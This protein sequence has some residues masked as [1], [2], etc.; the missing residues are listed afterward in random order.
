MLLSAWAGLNPD[1]LLES[2][3]ELRPPG[4]V[5]ERDFQAVCIRCGHC[6]QIC[7]TTC[8]QPSILETGVAGFMTPVARMR[9]G[10]C[11][12]NCRACGE[13]CPTGAIR[14]LTKPEKPFAKIGNAIIDKAKCIV[15]EQG[16]PCLVCDENCPWG[17]IYWRQN[18]RGERTP[19][20]DENRCNGCGQ[21]EH[22]CPVVGSAAIRVLPAGRIRLAAGSFASEARNRG[23]ILEE[24][25]EGEYGL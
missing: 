9:L 10:P 14:R 6:V 3:E 11:D 16:K 4:A 12:P 1:R 23:L 20:V 5:P 21:C 19:F 7:P 25:K 13:V 24:K 8:L 15:W 17:A 22:A 2:D 18:E